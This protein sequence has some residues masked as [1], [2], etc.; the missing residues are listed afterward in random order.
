MSFGDFFFGSGGGLDQIDLLTGG[1]QD[2]LNDLIRRVLGGQEGF[3]F[4]ED[5]FQRSFVDPALRQFES[6]TAPSIQ[7]K[8]IS[9]GAG[10]GSNLED[11]LTRA[12]ADVQGSLD[13]KRAEL[14]NQ[15][16]NRQLQGAQTALGT[17]AF[18][19]QQDPGSE[20]FSSVLLPALGAIGGGFIGGPAGAQIGA[21]L[22][23]GAATGLNRGFRR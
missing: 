17:R 13:Q 5:F 3:G 21:G 16:L 9:A 1:Q 2:L 12:G 4:D 15:A 6:R 14:L 8:F 19:L 20:G 18:G 23:S 7:Q 11:A 10:R 22:G